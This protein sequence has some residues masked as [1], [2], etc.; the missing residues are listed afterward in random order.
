LLA[1]VIQCVGKPHAT[2]RLGG[3]TADVWRI[4]FEHR[5]PLILKLCGPGRAF[6]QELTALTW[7]ATLGDAV[8]HLVA[9]SPELRAIL[10]TELQREDAIATPPTPATWRAAGRIRAAFDRLDVDDDP[11]PLAIAIAQRR[12][13]WL[14]RARAHLDPATIARARIAID[15]AAF[16]ARTRSFCHR[17][18]GPHNWRRDPARPQWL[19]CVDFGQARADDPLVDLVRACAPP[20]D[21][22]ELRDAFIEGWGRAPDPAAEPAL[23][24]LHAIA[25]ATWGREHDDPA[26]IALGDLALAHCAR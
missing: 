5:A 6:T 17:D 1:Y 12:D 9:S 18:F 24:W 19:G 20:H 25:T 3:T 16:E 7:I 2:H 21:A 26:F 23:A 22:P 13:H 15:P 8:P 10:M 4:T 11:A 14:A